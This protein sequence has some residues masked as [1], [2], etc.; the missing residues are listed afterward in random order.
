MKKFF[1][2]SKFYIFLILSFLL[3]FFLANI[4][5]YDYVIYF[6]NLVIRFVQNCIVN[7]YLTVFFKVITN[8]GDAFFFLILLLI[9]LILFKNKNI[10]YKFGLNLFIVY[11]VSVIFKN[12]F[13]RER[14]LYNLITKPRD[15]SFPSG[16]TMCSVAFYG[17]LIY[18]FGKKIENRFFRYFFNFGCV[19]IIFIV[20]FSRIYLNVHYFSDVLCGF[21]LGI[22][23]LLMFINY[24]RMILKK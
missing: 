10:F 4:F 20:A 21:L 24:D 19:F 23:C 6:D 22:V 3:L 12:L 7:E 11:L 8:F 9:V 14:P 18:Y 17:F 5:F 1:D 13:R 15:F 2:C 16:H